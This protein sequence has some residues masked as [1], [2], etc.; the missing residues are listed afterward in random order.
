MSA[1]NTKDT[2]VGVN[3]VTEVDIVDLIG[4]TLVHITSEDKVENSL[5]GKDTQLG[6]DTEELALGDVAALGDVEVLE[7]RLQVDAA[8]EDCGSVVLEILLNLSLFLWGAL[9]V[10]ASGSNGILASDWL[11][12][13]NGVLINTLQSECKVDGG[14]ELG[15]GEVTVVVVSLSESYELSISEREVEHG[16]H[17]A[18]LRHGDLALAELVEVTEELLNSHTLHHNQSLEALLDIAGV[19]GDV[20]SCLEVSV[21]KN[22][23]VLGGSGEEVAG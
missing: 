10:L 9:Q 4:V 16:Q 5:W 3:L 2:L 14:T 15:I 20:D 13:C 7:L 12:R 23:D 19:V 8:V 1:A 6:K 17:G 21:L 22:V 11:N 18:E